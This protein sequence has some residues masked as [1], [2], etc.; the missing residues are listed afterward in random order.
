MGSRPRGRRGGRAAP[1]GEP[2]P[3]G[4]KLAEARQED[5]GARVQGLPP[6]GGG[7]AARQARGCMA[8][9]ES[10]HLEHAS[11]ERADLDQRSAKLNARERSLALSARGGTTLEGGGDAARECLAAAERTILERLRPSA[12]RSTLGLKCLGMPF[13]C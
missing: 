4:G 8:G 12:S 1:G 7:T 2:A 10:R 9:R 3:S 13:S 11:M 6:G 5:L